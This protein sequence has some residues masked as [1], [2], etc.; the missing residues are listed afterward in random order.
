MASLHELEHRECDRLT[1]SEFFEEH[2]PHQ[3]KTDS[4]Y[5]MPQGICLLKNIKTYADMNTCVMLCTYIYI[6]TYLFMYAYIYIHYVHTSMCVCMY[7]YTPYKTR[8]QDFLSTRGLAS[9]YEPRPALGVEVSF[10][11]GGLGFR[12]RGL[13]LRV[14]SLGFRGLIR[15]L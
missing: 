2:S 10:D 12:A 4:I 9:G 3:Q 8:A 7:T 5:H 13:G 15:W 1:G 6:H 14:Q 11:S